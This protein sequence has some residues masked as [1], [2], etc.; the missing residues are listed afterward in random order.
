M[1]SLFQILMLILDVIWF[2]IIAH[3][4]MSW[5]INFQVLNLRQPLVAQIW[6]GLNRILEPVYSTIRRVLPPMG[7]LD[8]APLVA[9]IGIYAI[10]I[11]L[12]NN[13]GFFYGF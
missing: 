12:T 1:Q 5:L 3:V 6:D 11:I 13:A 8:L 7:G 2:I 10:R 4:I 9:L